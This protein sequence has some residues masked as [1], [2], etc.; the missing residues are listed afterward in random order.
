MA[1]IILTGIIKKINPSEVKGSFEKRT[2]HL[3]EEKDKYPS[4][5]Q[6]ETHQ[7]MCNALDAYTTGDKVECHVDVVG[8]EWNDKAFNTLKCYRIN[9]L[10][11]AQREQPAYDQRVEITEPIENLP[12]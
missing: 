10:S 2:F 8:R 5:W 6:L 4:V 1:N 3:G 12:F 7:T 11:S 9:K